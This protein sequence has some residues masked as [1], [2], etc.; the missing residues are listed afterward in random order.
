MTAYLIDATFGYLSWAILI[1][2]IWGLIKLAKKEKLKT[3]NFKTVFLVSLIGVI[4]PT[5]NLV[6]DKY[7]TKQGNEVSLEMS[8]SD[9]SSLKTI[10]QSCLSG[11]EIN[12][13]THNAFYSI[14]DKYKMSQNDIDEM[15]SLFYNEDLSLLQKSFYEDALKTIQKGRISESKIRLELQEKYLNESQK[16]RNSEYLRKVLAKEA[17]DINGEPFILDEEI[18]LTI[19]ENIEEIFTIG[20]QNINTLKNR[21]AYK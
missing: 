16:K 5:F 3:I 1:L 17:I 21:Q 6:S 19:I 9:K 8:E 12:K 14:V 15:F 13:E 2:L 20:K 7:Q 18:C 4:S 10:I 11:Q